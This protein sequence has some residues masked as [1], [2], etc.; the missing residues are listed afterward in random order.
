MFFFTKFIVFVHLLGFFAP[1]VSLR[2]LTSTIIFLESVLNAQP[3][4]NYVN[5]SYSDPH[6][7]IANEQYLPIND[8]N[9]DEIHSMFGR[10]ENKYDSTL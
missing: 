5:S 8:I 1:Q 10:L 6:F 4:F 2:N 7:S 9:I 3:S